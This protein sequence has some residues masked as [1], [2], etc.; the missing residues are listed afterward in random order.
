MAA[1]AER[2]CS[3]AEAGGQGLARQWL[4]DPVTWRLAEWVAPRLHADKP[5]GT[6]GNETDLAT[7]GSSAGK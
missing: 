6:M 5:G 4:I 1:G 3:K 2:T 7:Q